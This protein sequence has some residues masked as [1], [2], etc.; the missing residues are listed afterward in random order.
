MLRSLCILHFAKNDKNTDIPIFAL[1]IFR[2]RYIF[3]YL[4]GI[5][6]IGFEPN[7][8]LNF[9]TCG[10]LCRVFSDNRLGVAATGFYDCRRISQG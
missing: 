9:F 3:N 8:Y 10:P 1:Q 7:A 5:M 6:L 4:N 2:H